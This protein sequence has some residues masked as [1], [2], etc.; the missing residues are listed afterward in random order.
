MTAGA[1]GTR[2]DLANPETKLTLNGSPV[3]AD[4]MRDLLGWEVETVLGRP[5]SLEMRFLIPMDGQGTPKGTGSSSWKP[6][7]PVKL[8]VAKVVLFEGELTSV[9]FE[10]GRDRPSEFVLLAYDKRHRLY[11]TETRKSLPDVSA[12]DVVSRLLGEAGLA[13]G[14]ISAKLPKTVHKYHLHLGTAGDYIDRLCDQF[15]LTCVMENGKVSILHSSDLT[16]DAGKLSINVELLDYRFRRTTSADVDKVVVTSWDP[17]KKEAITGTATRAAGL[18]AGGLVDPAKAQT[19]FG[20][21]T[22]MKFSTVAPAQGDAEKDALGAMS[23]NVDAGMQFEGSALFKPDC[24]AGS[25]ITIEHAPAPYAGKYRLTSV[26]HVFDLVEGHR[27]HLACRGAD[28]VTVTGILSSA[29]TASTASPPLDEKLHGVYPAIVS[30]IKSESAKGAVGDGGSAGEVKVKMPWLDDT[31]ESSWMRVVCVGGGADRGLFVLPEINDEVLVAF[32]FGDPR[33]GYVLGGLHNG[34]DKAP[35]APA[36]L[37]ANDGRV[38]QRVW[39]SKTGHTIILSDKS[40]E[41]FI[42][43]IDK[44]A[45]NWVKINSK[46]NSIE[47]QNEGDVKATTKGKVVVDAKGAVN[48]KTVDDVTIEGKN[49]TVK[50]TANL[51]LEA[52]ANATLKGTA[53]AKVEAPKVDI[54]GTGPTTVKGNPIMLN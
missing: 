4:A 7:S 13:K 6:G 32:E 45:K 19:A 51:N 46:D 14:R 8:E 26:R 52:T 36:K 23:R 39:K 21:A 54:T 44:T 49:V 34:K 53:G 9:D 25:T 10:G 5:D 35:V 24:R 18:P 17:K 31:Y 16:T 15:G 30:T 42:Q 38:D 3:G 40:G 11:R 1:D 33:R 27:T 50:A 20:K 48:V 22:E 12:E 43:I 29:V 37:G 41:E 28:D 2:T 47:L